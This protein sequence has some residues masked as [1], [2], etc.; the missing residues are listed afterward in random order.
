MLDTRIVPVRRYGRLFLALLALA[1]CGTA[2]RRAPAA[3]A[4]VVVSADTWAV[5]DGRPI[6]RQDVEQA[7]RRMGDT[8]QPVSDD[9]ALTAKLNLLN[10]LVLQDILIAKA[11]TLNLDVSQSELDAAY[12]DAKK[13]MPDTAFQ[14]ELKRRSLTPDD[15]RDGLRRELL[16]Q[17]VISQEV[18]SKIVVTDKEVA[19]AFNANRAQF[20]IAEESY[21]LAQIVVTPV[22]D[23]QVANASGDDAGTPQQAAA[24][25]QM[26]MERLKAGAS[27][28]DLAA[29]YSEDPESAPRGGDLGL[30]P[31][32][33]LKQ[34]PPPLRDAVLNKAPGTVN[35]ANVGGG[36][37][38]V[39]VISHEPAGQRDLS[40]PDVRA[41]ITDGLRAR[42][43]QL[44]RAAYLTTVRG[45]ANVVNYLARRLVEQK[46]TV[47]GLQPAAPGAR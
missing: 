18:A 3:S 21:R 16:T 12:N 8:S 44:L 29:G 41:G 37:T 14:E 45:D 47:P 22:R 1:A 5:V 30:V 38:L 11:R 2:C 36:Y 20:N 13:N 4:T 6:T 32:S 27:F 10:D 15:M 23:A 40:T 25:V 34:A 28:Q 43:E 33:R 31:I 7:Y 39:L 35:V 9:E 17:K 42:K 26:L 24:K 19:D 46:G